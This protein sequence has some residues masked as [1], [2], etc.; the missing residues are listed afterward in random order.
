MPVKKIKRKLSPSPSV[1][2]KLNADEILPTEPTLGS[3]DPSNLKCVMM[4]PPK[5]GKTSF[6]SSHP[7]ALLMAFEEG[8]H[9]CKTR[10]IV[11]DAWDAKY[12]SQIT[13]DESGTKHMTM[14]QAV[15]LLEQTDRYRL[16]IFDTADMAVK[17]CSDYECAKRKVEHPADAGDYGKG[18]DVAQNAPFRRAVLRLM[19]TGRGIAFL[20]HSKVTETK[21]SKG[22]RS[23]RESTLPGGIWTFLYSQAD[24]ILH[25]EFGKKRVGHVGIPRLLRLKG[26]VDTL[27][28]SRVDDRLPEVY[29]VD[30]KE[31]W[32][33]FENFFKS[34]KAA[35]LAE[36]EAK[37][38]LKLL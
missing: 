10:K 19:K 7:D 32:K 25:G 34:E 24:V 14:M 12:G 37:P 1:K 17:M 15:D 26:D 30:R 8:H 4:A 2:S 38:F 3:T 35:R 27:A 28:G 21:F 9:F 22:V 5:W 11:I 16:I 29:V 20:T 6:F 18:F 33:Q 23:K 31:Q 36:R 13:T